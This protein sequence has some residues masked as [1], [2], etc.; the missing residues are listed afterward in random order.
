MKKLILL[1][2]V[3]TLLPAMVHAT[4]TI[5]GNACWYYWFSDRILTPQ[6]VVR[7]E[8][9]YVEALGPAN[10][11]VAGCDQADTFCVWFESAKGWGLTADPPEDECHLL[12]PNTLWWQD[13]YVEVPCDAPIGSIDTVCGYMEYCTDEAVCPRLGIDCATPDGMSIIDCG[14]FVVVPSPPALLVLQDSLYVVEAGATTAYIPFAVCNGDPCALPTDYDY[15]IYTTGHISAVV[16]EGSSLGV[17]GGECANVYGVIDA[18]LATPCDYDTLTIIAWT[19]GLPDSETIY[20]T[21]VQ[22]V[23]IVEPVPVPL[24]TTPVVTI[25]VLSMILAAA[26]L[27]KRRAASRA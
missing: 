17:P 3:A 20:D 9:F 1:A 24:F 22:L 11:A 26:V 4:P 16:E 15:D 6:P 8:N 25:L 12:N 23:H 2:L 5:E 19:A 18:G 14:Y 13:L 21:C 10:L 27:M 7:G